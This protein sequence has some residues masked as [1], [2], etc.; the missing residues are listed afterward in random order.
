[1]LFTELAKVKESKQP[2]QA[3]VMTKETAVESCSDQKKAHVSGKRI[4]LV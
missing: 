2:P 4:S 1:M 3:A